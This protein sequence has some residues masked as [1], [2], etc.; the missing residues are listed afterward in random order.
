M[1]SRYT[2]IVFF[3]Q[4]SNKV[5]MLT[6]G[7]HLFLDILKHDLYLYHTVFSVWVMISESHTTHA[8]MIDVITISRM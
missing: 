5:T 2:D 8:N 6:E 7:K 3:V 4:S 1:F